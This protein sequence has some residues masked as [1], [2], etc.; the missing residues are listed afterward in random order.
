MVMTIAEFK[1]AFQ[2]SAKAKNKKIR[3]GFSEKFWQTQTE[4]ASVKVALDRLEAASMADRPARVQDVRN[5]MAGVSDKRKTKYADALKL[6]EDGLNTVVVESVETVAGPPA[7]RKNKTGDG[8][9]AFVMD[10]DD[11]EEIELGKE[12]TPTRAAFVHNLMGELNRLSAT[13]GV[14]ID[15]LPG[16]VASVLKD[17]KMGASSSNV[18]DSVWGEAIAHVQNVVL[19]GIKKDLKDM[20]SSG[21][22]GPGAKI[23][24]VRFT[25]SD[26]HK[27]GK[28]V[29][30]L[31]F[32]DAGKEKKV[33][34]KPS[35]LQVDALLF[36]KDSVADKLGGVDTYNIVP[37]KTDDVPPADYGYM[38]FVDTQGGPSNAA[39]VMKVYKSIA[40]AMAMSY[41]VGLED[42]HHENVLMKKG[43]VQVIDMEATTGTFL[44]PPDDKAA[45]SG[46][47]IDQ[48]WKKAINDGFKATLEKLINDGKLTELPD[49]GDIEQAMSDEFSRV[50][51]RWADDSLKD[52]LEELETALKGQKTRIVPMP[53]DA[54]QGIIPFAQADTYRVA[55][56]DL[57]RSH[58][59]WVR[60]VDD[61]TAKEDEAPGSTMMTNLKGVTTTPMDTVRNLVISPGAWKALVRGDVP[62]FVRDLGSS[63]VFDEEGNKIAV[64][65][66][67]KVGKDIAQEMATRR[68]TSPA[69]ALKLFKVQGVAEVRKMN[70]S[71]RQK[72]G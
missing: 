60:L 12:L 37:R 8:K 26:F 51:G 15:D 62:Y 63:D 29:L 9:F 57:P 71:L 28:Q 39:D 68:T 36:G 59:N 7:V 25:G 17:T 32:N 34:Y 58:A 40:G 22:V 23:E 2:L 42:V 72:L 53:T 47:F 44:M 38:E 66:L 43:S 11:D 52:D 70:T 18:D 54:L 55:G 13:L 1:Q 14:K 56:V 31:R 48:Q 50:A 41:Y 6:V 19:P 49:D 5:A 24:G 65:G 10:G 20:A 67:K 16:L 64:P 35:N 61:R 4:L 3:W 46:G 27:G 21:L 33:V 45:M 30:I 69:A